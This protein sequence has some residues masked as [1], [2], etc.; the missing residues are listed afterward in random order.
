MMLP[1][2][3]MLD[4]SGPGRS[5]CSSL[6]PAACGEESTQ[7][8]LQVE[9]KKNKKQV[10]GPLKGSC[11][12]PQLQPTEP[13]PAKVRAAGG[14]NHRPRWAEEALRLWPPPEAE[15]QVVSHMQLPSARL[16]Q[17]PQDL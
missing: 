5:V 9:S 16:K 8:Q 13:Q 2:V 11:C 14:A 3:Q 17:E 10:K 4:R 15:S 1:P 12:S 7:F 6:V